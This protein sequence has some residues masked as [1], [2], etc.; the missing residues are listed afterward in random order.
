LLIEDQI[1]GID[2]NRSFVKVIGQPIM[3]SNRA[4]VS[5]KLWLDD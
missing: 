1:I 3:E 4:N 2:V 5:G